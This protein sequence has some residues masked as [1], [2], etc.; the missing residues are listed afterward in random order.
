MFVSAVAHRS[1]VQILLG[2]T[3]CASLLLGPNAMFLSSV[4]S[5]QGEN[6]SSKRESRP[7]PGKP[8]GNL[9]DLE[10]V[11]DESHIEREP[12]APIPS[13]LRSPKVPLNPWNG[14]RV[15][16]PGT[17][18]GLGQAINRT[19]RAH[20]GRRAFA[21]PSVLD[22]QFITNF[23]TWAV[24]R[25]PSG[26]EPTFWKDQLRV[27]YGQGQTSL[28]LAAVELGKTLFE[29]AEYAA[30]NRNASEYVNDL[31]K[32]YLMRDPDAGGWAHWTTEVGNVGRENVRRAFEECPEFAGILANVV[33]NGAPTANAASLISA[34]VNPKNQP[35]NGMLTRDGTWSVALLSLP[36]RAGLDLGLGLS[37][38]SMVWTRSG[39]Y[40]HF[41][42]DNGFPSPGFR[43][44]FPV[45]QRRVFDAQ[46]AKNSFL[47]ITAA[48]RRVELRQV[49]TSNVYEAGDSS[50]LQLIDSS[51]NLIVRSTD[52]TQLSFVEINNEYS[53]TQIKDRNGNYITVNH[54]ALGRITAVTDTL[55]RVI[56]FNYDVNQNLVSLTQSWNGQPSHQWVAFNWGT[57]TMQSSFSGA[58]VIGPKN[59]TQLPVITGVTLND[60]S[61]ITFDYNNS[62][63]V[64]LIRDYFGALQRSETTFTYETPAGDAPRLTDSRISAHNWTGINGVP[65][66][67]ITTYSV[68]GDGA[69]VMTTPDGT[70]YKQYY[71]T[72]WQRGLTTLSEVWRGIDKLK[73]TTMAWTQDNTSVGYEVNPRVTE[74][75]VYDGS[76]NRHRTVIDYG[77]YAQ[78]GLPYWVKEFAADGSTEIRHTFTDYNLSQAYLDK[79][80][81]GLV[82]AVHL[83]NATDY[84]SK[85]TYSYDDPARLQSVPAAATQH[86]TAYSTSL[87]ARGNVTSVSRWDVTDINNAFKA[88]TSYT[89]YYTTGTPSSTT[90][91]SGHPTTIAYGDSFS[92]NGIRNTFAYPTTVTDADNFSSYIQYN[93]DF[94][95]TTRTQSPAP[96]GQSQGAIQTMIYNNLGQ[97][98]RITTAN[99]GAYKRF[100]YGADY[101]ASYGTVN[102]VADELYSI[103]TF[104]GLG[105][106]L[107]AAS[108]HPGSIGAFR[109]QLNIYDLMGRVKKISNPAEVTSSWVP[110]GDDAAGWLYTQQTYDWKGRPL[111]TTNPD[112]TTREASYSGCGCA[113]GEIVTLTDEGTIDAGV[114][115]RRQ[116]K[117]HSDV[118]GRT[119]KTEI[120]NWQNSNTVYSATVNTYNARDQLT[121]VRE[122]AGAEGSGTYQDTTMTYDGYGRLK[123]KH[124]PEQDQNKDTVWDYNADGTIQKITDARGSSQTFA[125]NAR[126]LVT[127]ISYAA[128]SGSGITAPAT[129]TFSYDAAGNRT[130]MT[131]G[132]GTLSLSY[133]Q[134]SR[135]T[136]ETRYF[137]DLTAYSGGGNYSL[138]YQYNL[139]NALT[140][141]TQPSQFSGTVN[142]AYDSAARLATVTGSGFGT[143]TQFATGIQYRAW[144]GIKQMSYGSGANLNLTYTQRLLPLRYELG[145]VKPNGGSVTIMG[146]Q[147]QYFADGRVKYTQDLQ[148]GNFD[149]AYEYDHAGR[150]KEAYSGREARGLAVLP[151]P[152]NPFRQSYTY[153]VW[154]NM[155]R[156]ANRHWS[157]G[158][159]DNPTFINNRRTDATYDAAGEIT[160][161]DNDRK[162][163]TFDASGRQ[164]YFLQQE[165]G[166]PDYAY[167]ANSIQI[168][169]DGDGRPA[170][171]FENRYTETYE[172]VPWNE[173][174]TVY[175]VRSTLLGG[176]P[177]IEFVPAGYGTTENVYMGSQKIALHF[178]DSN[179]VQWRHVNP[180]TGSWLVSS[181]S[182]GGAVT[183][184][185][186]LD[187]LGTEMGTT[188]PYVSYTS[189]QD[190]IGLESLYEERGN[191]FDPSGGCG[192]VDGLPISCSE[193]R[194][195][196]QGGSVGREVVVPVAQNI[197]NPT[198]NPTKPSSMI[199]ATFRYPIISLGVGIHVSGF[200][201]IGGGPVNNNNNNEGYYLDTAEEFFEE[202][203]TRRKDC[204]EF[205]D[206]VGKIAKGIFENNPDPRT[207]SYPHNVSAF[208]DALASRFTEVTKATTV[209]MAQASDH[210]NPS[211][212]FGTDNFATRFIDRQQFSDNQ[213]RHAIFGL[214]IGY[215]HDGVIT[216]A[217]SWWKY[218]TPATATALE[219]ANAREDNSPSGLADKA[220]NGLTVPMG[221]RLHG[222]GAEPLARDLAGWIRNNLC[223]PR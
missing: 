70:I 43:L 218:G 121:Q 151:Y 56:N 188:D 36:G 137:N 30:R 212:E 144:G 166:L 133:D 125:Y 6:P 208:M 209:A 33:P 79:R 158:L 189:Y 84:E 50:Y 215:A 156:P 13:T 111:V 182:L 38:S 76:G 213:A 147:N 190:L 196:L 90:D 57:R 155:K 108:N 32:T 66:Q 2:L 207:N 42:E 23:F 27:A 7:K 107:G 176:A 165:W 120:Y 4:A 197:L 152:D 64:Y 206:E 78:W 89:N 126:H 178:T 180:A 204:Y 169:Y 94:G 123:K 174:K 143:I 217:G 127:S 139:A 199:L 205:A 41:D 85:I 28:K 20:A 102:N 173:P 86:D 51:P 15:G 186:E 14:K 98:E 25:S 92:D 17:Q 87:T 191:P 113:G 159:P 177:I 138:G 45:V 134:L 68:A 106:P 221:E 97:L 10:D 201:T 74:T 8:E 22:D 19:R 172:E 150:I 223:A 82:S 132:V 24:L 157:A 77:P 48:G 52:G 145:N 40:I 161:R 216:T 115:K 60:T 112:N 119:I 128:P 53:C 100:W 183:Y 163:H 96:A 140:T 142:Y 184:R 198:S 69:C 136:S 26:D 67:V 58:A 44:G 11:Q 65:S 103:R 162:H 153:D 154:N 88:L 80:I 185:N 101:T 91:P 21:P 34:R 109:A 167:E 39:P 31:Y 49:G 29:S 75:N 104:D 105:R 164:S 61:Q 118:L 35:G 116:T 141:L 63:Q 72:G 135:L 181:Q 73:W 220:L 179:Y 170:K 149:R 194:M 168:T 1:A 47:F 171:R 175:Y 99:N 124:V 210:F 12:A 18:T 130:S 187:P 5:A 202:P 3:L 37:Y 200:P 83:K 81:I 146:S 192:T 93:F 117:I 71:G 55:G 59:G 211:T 219:V 62:L 110:A 148:D 222:P 131:D 54:N 160:A 95:A 9:P 129:P 203:Q 16:D 114:A 193:L 195:R 122:Y 46:T 214:V